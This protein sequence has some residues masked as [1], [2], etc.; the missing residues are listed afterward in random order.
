MTKERV[1]ANTQVLSRRNILPAPA[2]SRKSAILRLFH[3]HQKI[4]ETASNHKCMSNDSSGDAELQSL[5]YRR[6][7]EIEAEMMALPS[8]SAADLAAKMIVAHCN[9]DLSCLPWD[10]PVWV[11]ARALISN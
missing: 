8:S 11:E 10:D 9:G 4:T 6:T 1:C 3:R 2:E 7:D 5:F